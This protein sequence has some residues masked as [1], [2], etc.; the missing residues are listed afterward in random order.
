MRANSLRQGKDEKLA[1]LSGILSKYSIKCISSHNFIFCFIFKNNLPVVVAFNNV[2]ILLPYFKVTQRSE[3]IG[4]IVTCVDC[5]YKAS[6]FLLGC[7][8]VYVSNWLPT[9]IHFP[10]ML[11]TSYIRCVTF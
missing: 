3:N 8:T 5:K 11:V 1:N 4:N 6:K 7:Y 9:L 10:E 2:R